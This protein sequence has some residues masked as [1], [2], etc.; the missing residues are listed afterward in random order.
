MQILRQGNQR[1]ER[2][3]ASPSMNAMNQ[4]YECH[5]AFPRKPHLPWDGKDPNPLSTEESG[6]GIPSYRREDRKSDSYPTVKNSVDCSL[7]SNWKLV[8]ACS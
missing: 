6:I 7:D 5:K 4:R 2:L 1:Y 8:I 3:L